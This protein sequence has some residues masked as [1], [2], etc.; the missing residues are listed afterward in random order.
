MFEIKLLGKN[1]ESCVLPDKEHKEVNKL[2]TWLFHK[3]LS[4]V[5]YAYDPSSIH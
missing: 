2:K 4:R 1:R 3:D 5:G